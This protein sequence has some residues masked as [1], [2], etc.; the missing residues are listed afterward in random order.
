MKPPISFPWFLVALGFFI[1]GFTRGI[2][3][4]F[5]VFYVAVLENYHWSRA[6]TASVFSLNVVVDALVSPLIGHLIDRYG[7]KKIV[8]LGVLFLACGLLLTSQMTSLWQFY[9][10]FGLIT[11]LGFSFTG[12]IPHIVLVS[13]WFSSRRGSAL[14]LVYAGTGTG[15]LVLAPFI[16]WLIGNWGW[17]FALEVLSALVVALVLPPVLLF[18]RRGPH[19]EPPAGPTATAN[20]WTL[21][22]ALRSVQFWALFFARINAASGTTVIV[23]HQVAHVVDAGYSA[24]FAAT[25]FGLM[26][27]TSSC[28]RMVFGF[29]ADVFSKPAAY[30]ANIVA[31]LIGVGALMLASDPS[32]TWLLYVYVIFFGIGFGSRAVIFSALTADIFSGK[33]FGAIL[34][35]FTVSVGIGSA[36]G[37][38]L[39]G[40]LH[41]A[42]GN[43]VTAFLASILLLAVS[44]ACVWLA[45]SD[46]ISRRDKRLWDG[47][48]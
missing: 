3:A 43:Y 38:W 16:Q 35:S 44:D 29:I 22:L 19:L 33:R 31:T 46:W 21:K 45:T 36:L 17:T 25:V 20:P 40:F 10:F 37:S 28:G 23:T 24:L 18:Y 12:M 8:A 15:I 32:Q 13:Q 5:G 47:A 2:H 14:G 1:M 7:V 39:G 6:L 34:G 4:S 48:P 27:V 9:L 26:G 30:T 42:S 41:D 11:A